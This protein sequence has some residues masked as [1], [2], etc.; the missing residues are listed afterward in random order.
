MTAENEMLEQVTVIARLFY[1][2][3]AIDCMADQRAEIENDLQRLLDP[4]ST[5]N[6]ECCKVEILNTQSEFEAHSQIG[7]K[8]IQALQLIKHLQ[9]IYPEQSDITRQI[10]MLLAD[11]RHV[12]DEQQL[13]FS[14]Q[15]RKAHSTYIAEK[16]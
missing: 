8:S 13:S 1:Q 10:V 6:A 4:D 2:A 12:C 11:V 16:F 7:R 14:E 9:D 3:K 5:I 15:D